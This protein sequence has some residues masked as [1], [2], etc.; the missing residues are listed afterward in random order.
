MMTI[1][2]TG[3]LGPSRATGNRASPALALFAMPMGAPTAGISTPSTASSQVP[4]RDE[5][6]EHHG[7][8]YAVIALVAAVLVLGVMGA[9]QYAQTRDTA[10][11]D[12]RD[13]GCA[14]GVRWCE[15][16]AG[17]AAG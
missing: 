17:D 5:H 6:R 16:A 15:S 7:W 2:P 14:G 3:S 4:H 11:D 9:I 8:I 1:V 12:R 13:V 10:I